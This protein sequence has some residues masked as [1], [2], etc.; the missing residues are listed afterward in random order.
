M[1]AYR[2]K[3]TPHTIVA[4]APMDAPLQVH[5]SLSELEI[6]TMLARELEEIDELLRTKPR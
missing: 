3:V 2:P 1:K 4:L 6:E 5:G